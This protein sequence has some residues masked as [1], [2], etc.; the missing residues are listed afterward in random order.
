[1]GKYKF[2]AIVFII[3]FILAINVGCDNT[4]TIGKNNKFETEYRVYYSA[5]ANH[6]YI[7]YTDS[8]VITCS[9]NGTNY[10]FE[11][12]QSEEIISTTAPIRIVKQYKYDKD[13]NKSEF[14]GSY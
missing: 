5:R 10:L 14:T 9:F 1:M 13:G 3:F 8:E 11:K 2:R 4:I 6:D 7:V 12:G